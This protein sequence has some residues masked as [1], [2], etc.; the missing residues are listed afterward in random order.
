MWE[1]GPKVTKEHLPSKGVFLLNHM[2]W[3]SFA[4]KNTKLWTK[5][6]VGEVGS[7]NELREKEKHS[8]ESSFL[9]Y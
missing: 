6:D 8:Q 2:N 1:L 7:K 5:H 3:L 9:S 4:I